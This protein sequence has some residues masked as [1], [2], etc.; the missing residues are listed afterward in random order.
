ME[1]KMKA[2]NNIAKGTFWSAALFYILIV[3]EFA[4]MAGPFAVYFYS[5]YAPA[6]NFFN[7][8]PTL[9]WLNSFFLPHIVRNTS[10]VMLDSMVLMG[11]GAVIAVSG[12]LAFCIGACQVYYSKLT[13][14]GVVTGGLYSLSI[15]HPQYAAFIISSFGLTI[16]WPRFI[17]VL[18][19]ITM[20][21]AYWLLATIEE[22][23]C[24]AKFGKSYIDYKNRTN[25]FLPF[26]IKLFSKIPFPK[27]GKKKAIVIAVSYIVAL[28]I[29]AGTA[30]GL[31]TLSINSLQ[32]VITDN[33]VNIAVSR[34]S[35]EKF[36]SVLLIAGEDSRVIDI[37]SY[38]DEDAQF[39]NYILPTEW[40][41]S[42]IPM[43]ELEARGGHHSPLN[44]DDNL[45]K[46]IIT[47][48][49]TRSDVVTIE[50]L[51]RNVHSREPIVEIWIDLYEQSVTQILDMPEH[52]M[53]D[54]IPVA[55][56]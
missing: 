11:V 7:D 20:V 31:Q 33:S 29:A 39:L 56:F 4:Y 47:R 44:Y 14:K 30:F 18:M 26:R 40:F 41:K 50:N 55:I 5:I 6:L 22:R 23:E 9:A 3:F 48:V 36:N 54:G 51:L 49:I 43:N 27:S 16:M 34:M 35:D 53:F 12:F 38:F 21:F 28:F 10:F 13:K 52:I 2:K 42:E 37:L 19:F 15:R 32:T 24:E 46:I 8:T 1:S 17:S 45:Y 25:M